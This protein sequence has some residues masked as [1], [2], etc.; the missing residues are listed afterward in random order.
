M[1]SSVHLTTVVS[2]SVCGAAECWVDTV[3]LAQRSAAVWWGLEDGAGGEAG[4]RSCPD[5]SFP[6]PASSTSFTSPAAL[7][8]PPLR[9]S[10]VTFVLSVSD[11]GRLDHHTFPLLCDGSADTRR[12][13]G[14][15]DV[16]IRGR[17]QWY[18]EP[19][20][21]ALFKAT[22]SVFLHTSAP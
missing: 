21:G 19:G 2:L 3:L 9:V 17:A 22:R 14:R 7:P 15:G 18:P 8:I 1:K 5:V 20:L 10:S 6:P 16:H 11:T 13:E 4:R 12:A